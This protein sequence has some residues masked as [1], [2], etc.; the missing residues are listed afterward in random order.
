MLPNLWMETVWVQQTHPP[1]AADSLMLPSAVNAQYEQ[2]IAAGFVSPL[3]QC[4]LGLAPDS[5]TLQRTSS[6]R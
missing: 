6:D 2:G 5:L 1:P 4:Q 3:T